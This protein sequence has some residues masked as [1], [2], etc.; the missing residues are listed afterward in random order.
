MDI[1][2]FFLHWFSSVFLILL[3]IGLLDE[4][5]FYVQCQ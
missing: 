3:V 1:Y 2:V 5:K 4:C